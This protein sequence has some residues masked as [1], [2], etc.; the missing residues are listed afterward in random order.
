MFNNRRL[1]FYIMI[2]NLL[3]LM[4]ARQLESSFVFTVI[5]LLN[6]FIAVFYPLTILFKMIR[7]NRFFAPATALLF[8]SGYY[9][10]AGLYD[11]AFN[12]SLFLQFLLNLFSI[13]LAFI[14]RYQTSAQEEN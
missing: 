4:F 13:S 7:M 8:T 3:M 12:T 11:N 14:M 1:T 5:I 2:A 10:I 9:M 6:F